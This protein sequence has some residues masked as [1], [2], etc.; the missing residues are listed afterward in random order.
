MIM[1]PLQI[2]LINRVASYGCLFTIFLSFAYSIIFEETTKQ[3]LILLGFMC[4][5]VASLLLTKSVSYQNIVSIAVFLELPILI[6]CYDKEDR[7]G[8]IGKICA[9]FLT[10]TVFYFS[11]CFSESSYHVGLDGY[12]HYGCFTLGYYNPNQLGLRLIQCL[13]VL[14]CGV[15]YYKQTF[16]RVVFSV[17]ALVAAY[18]ILITK[19]RTCLVVLVLAI[20]L[21]A[22]Q[23]KVKVKPIFVLLAF[24]VPVLVALFLLKGQAIY[25]DWVFLGEIFDYGRKGEF[26][27]VF[28]DINFLSAIFGNVGYHHFD[29]NHNAF[30]TI[31]ANLGILGFCLFFGVIMHKMLKIVCESMELYQNTAV[32]G[33]I[34][35][36]IHSSM[37]SS[38]FVEGS[39]LSIAFFML[40]L[41]ANT[42]EKKALKGFEKRAHNLF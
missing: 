28:K 6:F 40:Y 38:L 27:I 30:L 16:L 13:L 15:V 35:L 5:V 33:M 24:L 26:E 4:L 17:A 34:M 20:I 7:K 11:F 21:F 39:Y 19:S 12:V 25:K 18:M 32:V 22:I 3:G 42:T 9:V 23:I 8:V 14:L 37:E 1:T 36:I 41:I 10:A 2:E 31:F 29:N